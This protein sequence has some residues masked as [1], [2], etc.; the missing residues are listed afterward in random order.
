[1]TS[2]TIRKKIYV[3]TYIIGS[4]VFFDFFDHEPSEE[5]IVE[6]LLELMRNV[7]FFKN[8]RVSVRAVDIEI[9]YEN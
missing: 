9:E 6:S 2:K 1:M 7:G 3:V 8:V 4:A 5:D